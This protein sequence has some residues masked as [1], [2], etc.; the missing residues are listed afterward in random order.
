MAVVLLDDELS[1]IVLAEQSDE[2]VIPLRRPDTR[3]RVTVVRRDFAAREGQDDRVSR[4]GGRDAERR[5]ARAAAARPRP[6][7]AASP[8]HPTGRCSSACARVVEVTGSHG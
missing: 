8:P 2:I 7:T 4:R 6:G 3:T 5:G 1:S